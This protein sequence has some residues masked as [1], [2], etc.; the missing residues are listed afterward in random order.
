MPR[1][2]LVV[3][4]IGMGAMLTA[5]SVEEPAPTGSPGQAS[6]GSESA[7]LASSFANVR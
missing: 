6:S 5:C 2:M 1:I 4:A 3:M 7:G